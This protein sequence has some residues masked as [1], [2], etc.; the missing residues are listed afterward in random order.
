MSEYICVPVPL[1]ARGDTGPME[2]EL[3]GNCEL[4]DVETRKDPGPLQEQEMLLA[5][6]PLLQPLNV[7]PLALPVFILVLACQ[8]ILSAYSH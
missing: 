1:E 5:F 4:P 6:E 8:V 3:T 7:S 2:L